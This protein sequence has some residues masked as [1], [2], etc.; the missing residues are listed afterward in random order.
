MTAAKKPAAQ[1]PTVPPLSFIDTYGATV[2]IPAGEAQD[3]AGIK[4]EQLTAVTRLLAGAGAVGIDLSVS[5]TQHFTAMANQ[6]ACELAS[7]IDIVA[8][9]VARKAASENGDMPALADPLDR[10]IKVTPETMPPDQTHV[11]IF[12]HEDDYVVRA[13]YDADDKQWHSTH[14]GLPFEKITVKYW[15]IGSEPLTAKGGA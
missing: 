2:T 7:L 1:E 15:R 8:E 4:S 13:F 11:D 12:T 9:D 14:D 10:W 5:A 3:Y 6:L